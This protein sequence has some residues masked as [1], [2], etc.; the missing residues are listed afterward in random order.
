VS[1]GAPVPS[2]KISRKPQS[3]GIRCCNRCPGVSLRLVDL[4]KNAI[5]SHKTTQIAHARPVIWNACCERNV[6]P[7]GKATVGSEIVLTIHPIELAHNMFISGVLFYVW[8]LSLAHV[9]R[10]EYSPALDRQRLD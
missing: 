8:S 1:H 3:A 5:S 7:A 10:S 2:R 6:S 4:L 9:N